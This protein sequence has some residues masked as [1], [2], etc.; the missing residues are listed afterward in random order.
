MFGHVDQC[1]IDIHCTMEGCD[2]GK[3][4]SRGKHSCKHSCPMIYIHGTA[5]CVWDITIYNLAQRAL[6]PETR[7]TRGSKSLVNG[8]QYLCTSAATPMESGFGQQKLKSQH[9]YT[10]IYCIP[11]EQN[12]AY[13]SIA[14]LTY[15][16]MLSR[17]KHS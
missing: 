9:L 7:Y 12:C 3:L 5:M 6:Q 1:G 13:G 10:S 16:H 4:D 15:V 11:F 14:T 2:T 8:I 17:C